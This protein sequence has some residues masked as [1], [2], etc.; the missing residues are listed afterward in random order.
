MNEKQIYDGYKPIVCEMYPE[1]NRMCLMRN[2]GFIGLVILNI[3]K[4]NH[5]VRMFDSGDVVINFQAGTSFWLNFN[6]LKIIEECWNQMQEIR[7]KS[8]TLA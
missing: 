8:L 2:G 1:S 5:H 4:D 7:A 3:D 6:D